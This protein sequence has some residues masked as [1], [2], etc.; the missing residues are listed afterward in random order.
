[1]RPGRAVGLAILSL[2]DALVP[3]VV[4]FF[5]AL[6]AVPYWA[7]D[8]VNPLVLAGWAAAAA[9]VVTLTVGTASYLAGY[10]PYPATKAAKRVWKW[11]WH[12]SWV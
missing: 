6:F 11:S 9:F 8:I 1:M 3:T 7:D 4:A 12:Y 10:G 2:L 5:L